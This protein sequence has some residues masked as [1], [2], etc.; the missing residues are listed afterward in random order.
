MLLMLA[1]G[2]GLVASIGITQVMAKRNVPAEAPAANTTTI[3]VALDD[4]P[5]GDPITPQVIKLEQWPKDKVPAGAIAKLEDVENR[6]PKS[7]I[8]KGAPILENWLL[9]KGSNQGATAQIPKGY[10]VVAIRVDDVSASSNMIRPG[11]RVDIIV[12]VQKS[13]GR[14][15]EA[16]KTQT[17]LEDIKVFSVNDI[18]DLDPSG[19]E[20]KVAA[21][22]ISLLVTPAQAEKV[23]LATEMGKIRL[24]MRSFEDDTPV[25]STGAVP[26][27]LFG[28]TEASDRKKDDPVKPAK[29]APNSNSSQDAFLALLNSKQ[30]DPPAATA[31]TPSTA[32][33]AVD[34]PQEPN[35]WTMRVIAATQVNDV[36]MQ[37]NERSGA[38]PGTPGG[39]RWTTNS[40]PA[41]PSAKSG[42]TSG[43]TSKGSQASA[44]QPQ[45]TQPEP[46]PNAAQ[47]KPAEPTGQSQNAKL[48]G[49]KRSPESQPETSKPNQDGPAVE[50]G[51][52]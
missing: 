4:I 24:V 50:Q 5:T 22:T 13:A 30:P 1:L 44:D 20:N 40:A 46:T 51:D 42:S 25:N 14:G 26:E 9:P 19:H 16:T 47:D 6:R 31:A 36:V 41:D 23:T 12:Y 29:A 33:P 37:L 49:D 15:F 2:C 11:D 27:D 48:E 7:K 10:R 8:Y 45:N 34:G 17:I 3:F 39:E 43:K 52:D 38:A 18:Y 21:R 28:S 32:T 35:N